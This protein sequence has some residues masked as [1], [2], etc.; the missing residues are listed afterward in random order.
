MRLFLL[1]TRVHACAHAKGRY[2]QVALDLLRRRVVE[3][4]TGHPRLLREQLAPGLGLGFGLG[5]GLG[6]GLG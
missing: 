1:L 4:A 2:S 5:L 3:H 6:L